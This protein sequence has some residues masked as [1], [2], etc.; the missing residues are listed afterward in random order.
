MLIEDF[1][2]AEPATAAAVVRPC[3]DIPRW[4]DAIVG[5]RP[6]RETSALLEAADAAAR[7]WSPAEIEAAL[8]QHPRIGERPTGNDAE[9]V[10]SRAEQST[11]AA[12]D[13]ATLAAIRDG[14]A[15]YEARFDRVFLIRAAG[16]GADEILAELTRRMANTPAAEEREVAEELRQIAMLRLQQAVTSDEA[17]QTEAAA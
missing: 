11:A 16:R 14:N 6:Y 15:A 13:A 4:I 10:A 17:L 7:E 9:S 8:A 1:D 2:T 5:G 3:A 12:S